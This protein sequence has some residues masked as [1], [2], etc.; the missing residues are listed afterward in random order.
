MDFN[1]IESMVFRDEELSLKAGLTDMSAY[2]ILKAI[3]C[4]YMNKKISK[5]Q[6]AKE[7]K[8]LIKVYEERK[9]YE[10]YGKTAADMQLENISKTQQLRIK[11]N[12]ASLA[13]KLDKEIWLEAVECINR[14]CGDDPSYQSC[15]KYLENYKEGGEEDGS[16]D[17]G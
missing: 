14:L 16:K 12:K 15:V 7:K 4:L 2:Y 5:T 17:I 8:H 13:G 11:L 6:A 10:A 1:K 3:N 9:K